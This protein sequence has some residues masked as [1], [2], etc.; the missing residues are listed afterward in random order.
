M[1]RW[2]RWSVSRQK[3]A[4]QRSAREAALRRAKP[5]RIGQLGEK[6]GKGEEGMRWWREHERE[7][8]GRFEADLL[9]LSGVS[10]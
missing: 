10:S 9:G 7:R 8:G 3:S 4:R 1:E 2:S 5:G 6:G